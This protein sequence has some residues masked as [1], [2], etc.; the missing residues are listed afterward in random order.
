M[1]IF[2]FSGGKPLFSSFMGMPTQKE[3]MDPWSFG[4]VM[5]NPMA[6]FGLGLLKRSGDGQGFGSNVAGAFGDV[7]SGQEADE[8][9]AYRAQQMDHMKKMDAEALKLMQGGGQP[10][11]SPAM[12][13][14]KPQ[15]LVPGG[16]GGGRPNSAFLDP[17]YGYRG[18]MRR[19]G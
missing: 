7:S 4:N 14:P 15:A 13:Q 16:G 1:G 17:R 10:Q 3:G 9:R 8:A 6:R 11:V 12:P 5:G 2:N 19:M 18:G